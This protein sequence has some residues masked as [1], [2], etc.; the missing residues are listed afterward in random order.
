M[1]II[2]LVLL[3]LAALAGGCNTMPEEEPG[4]HVQLETQP[5][6]PAGTS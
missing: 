3:G 2:L 4:Y 1:R 6:G 5:D